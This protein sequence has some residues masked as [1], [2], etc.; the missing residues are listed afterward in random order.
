MMLEKLG[1]DSLVVIKDGNVIFRSGEGMLSPI[2]ACI[3]KHREA[4]EGSVV[5]DKVVGLGAAKLLVFAKAREI[6]AKIASRTAVDL[7]K[8]KIEAEKIV[9]MIMNDN[10]DEQ[11][12]MEK[13]A[14]KLTGKELFEKLN[15]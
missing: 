6:Y 8:G 7:L 2:I 15:K 5:I 13:L 10:G 14:E 11:C 9:D 1:N 12:P 3:N 4:M